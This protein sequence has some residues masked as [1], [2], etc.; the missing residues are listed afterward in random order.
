MKTTK[1]KMPLAAWRHL[2]HTV[3]DMNKDRENGVDTT[4]RQLKW[5]EMHGYI[6]ALLDCALIDLVEWKLLAD[7]LYYAWTGKE[8]TPWTF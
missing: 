1:T 6:R 2:C 4:T 7:A 5:E 3:T 8:K